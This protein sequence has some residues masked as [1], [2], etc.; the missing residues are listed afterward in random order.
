MS[1]A[2]NWPQRWLLAG[3]IAAMSSVPAAA[4]I[5]MLNPFGQ[6][7]N[8]I[9]PFKS[10]QGSVSALTTSGSTSYTSLAPSG[11][12]S[13][14]TTWGGHAWSNDSGQTWNTNVP[15]AIET[16]SNKV[17]FELHDTTFDHG[18]IDPSTKRRSE[19]SST[20]DKFYN[21][22]GYWMAFSFNVHWSCLACQ[23]KLNQGGEIMQVHWPSGASP[24][25]AFRTVPTSTGAA[26]TI[27]TR[28]DTTGNITR[29]T[30]PLSLDTV[31]DVVFHFQTGAVGYEE[32]WLDGKLISNLSNI[33]VGTDLEDGY[34]MRM[35]PYYGGGLN[36]ND[37]VQ[38]Y[39]NVAPF[40]ST[41]S[42]S[43]R[44]SSPPAW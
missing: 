43:A 37:V 13:K 24:A 19:F 25:L 41:T 2:K 32:V 9:Q 39:G 29:A 33:P 27:T 26:F 23:Q 6:R 16:A 21:H 10:P 20:K 7:P 44:I 1:G 34:A 30:V 40:P 38:E 31:H 18:Q 28:G 11:L 15:Y 3:S 22:I 8:V 42:L 14:Y 5:Q 12:A 17:R 35:G 36:G 4:Q